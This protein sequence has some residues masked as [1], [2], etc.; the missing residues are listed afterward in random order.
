MKRNTNPRAVP[1]QAERPAAGARSTGR[2][3]ASY[4]TLRPG[5]HSDGGN[6]YL[7]VSDGSEGRRR[8]SWI[9][10]YTLSGRKRRD[11][12]LG[13]LDD[14]TLAEARDVAREYRKLLKQGI[15][16]IGHRNTQ[17]AQNLA[18]SVAVMT[19][20]QAA[21]AYIRQ[22][23]AGWKNLD[24]A[25]QW[26][27]SLKN[28]ASP[29]IG[30]MSVAD[31]TT[32][33]VMK[34]LNPIWNEKTETASR[35]RGRIEA[36]LGW[37]TVSGYRQGENPARWRD[38]LDN[39]LASRGKVHSVKHQP[40]LPYTDMSAFIVDLHKRRAMAA[41]ALEF[42]ILTCVRSADVVNAKHADV[43]RTT[44]MWI[45]PAFS[46]TGV[47]HRVPLSTTA[48]AVFD[49]AR[50]IANEI[51]GDVGRSDFAFPNDVT[52]DHLSSN[53][54]LGVIERMGRKGA[55]TTHGFRASFRTWAQE[56]T[57]FPWELS[58]M[59]LGHKVGTKVERAYARG[60]A[61]K[62]RV[63]IMQAWADYCS[64][65]QQPG[66]VIQLQSRGA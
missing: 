41:L 21:E 30:R 59:A 6:L 62:K 44:R 24:H 40:A 63:A 58:E 35:V 52:G 65:P 11:M 28:H 26:Q 60:D 32:A 38:H 51:G 9:F 47:E 45:I 56:Q 12:G 64:R 55:A 8:R 42:A 57:N 7:Q 15:D 46:K 49:K 4:K 27:R 39:L 2:L 34:V 36:V 5:L 37:A 22:H 14:V 13:S 17:R 23:R 53:A 16:P 1:K 20:D 19:F 25:A 50:K 31:I 66:K 10:R 48:L 33:H 29:V 3:P 54:L 61:F 43:D 18:A